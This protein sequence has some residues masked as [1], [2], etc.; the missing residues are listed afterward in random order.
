MSIPEKCIECFMNV[1]GVCSGA[2]T[3]KAVICPE[4]YS[5]I[6]HRCERAET[7]P[8]AQGDEPCYFSIFHHGKIRDVFCPFES[9]KTGRPTTVGDKPLLN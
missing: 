5:G 3:N 8:E 2:L 9:D 1:P 7:C 6:L 4:F